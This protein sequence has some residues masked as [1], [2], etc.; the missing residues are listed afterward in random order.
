MMFIKIFQTANWNLSSDSDAFFLW[1]YSVL[2]V[3]QYCS[4]V[5]LISLN[6]SGIINVFLHAVEEAGHD[7][8]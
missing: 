8:K 2:T 5:S 7:S 6:E 3:Y 4:I 1:I